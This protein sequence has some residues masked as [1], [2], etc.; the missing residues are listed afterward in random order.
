MKNLVDSRLHNVY[1][2]PGEVFVSR[3]PSLVSTVLGSCVSVTLFSRSA[4]MGAICHAMLPSGTDQDQLRY[5]DSAVEYI[6]VQLAAISGQSGGFEAKLFG[7][8]NVLVQ[9]GNQQASVGGLNVEAAMRAIEQLELKLISFDTG[10]EQ[11]RKIF[12]Y[13][14]TGEVYLRSVKKSIRR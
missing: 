13:S 14:G 4:C 2:K 10:G 9:G 12:F 7:G 5:V 6:Y 3:T 11:G 1:L 8:A